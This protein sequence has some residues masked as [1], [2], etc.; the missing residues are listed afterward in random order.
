M[1]DNRCKNK[2][3]AGLE[4]QHNKCFLCG[5][6]QHISFSVLVFSIP[7]RKPLTNLYVKMFYS[8]L[9]KYVA[10]CLTC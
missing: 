1:E 6:F 7:N 10:C 3:N 9:L 4:M 2:K 8:L 5:K